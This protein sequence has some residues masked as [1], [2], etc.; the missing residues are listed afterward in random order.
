VLEVESPGPAGLFV[1]AGTRYPLGTTASGRVFLAFGVEPHVNQR[2]LSPEGAERSRPR[3]LDERLRRIRKRGYEEVAG[4]WLEAVVDLS[5]PIF[6]VRGE[7]I[8]ALAMPFLAM[9]QP[10]QEIAPARARLRAAASEISG[11]LGSGDYT[12]LLTSTQR[13]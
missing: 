4:E 8:A 5:W 3:D 12:A 1:R 11:A 13:T 6:D 2:P 9:G 7:I 10:R